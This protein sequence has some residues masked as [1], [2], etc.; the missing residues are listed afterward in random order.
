[1]MKSL[2]SLMLFVCSP[3]AYAGQPNVVFI[4][5]D[6]LGYGGL[7]CYGTRWLETPNIDGLCRE[8]MKFTEGLA[9]YPTCL[10]SRMAILT[11]QYGPRTGGYRVVDR[12]RGEEHLI[13]YLVPKN[14][15]LAHDK[16]TVAEC[17]QQAGY[18]TAMF[19]K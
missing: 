14:L 16:I 18:A 6:D 3:L 1:M 9:A 11:G 5:A 13:K 15:H 8:G 7:H 4:L 17:F 10:P 12:H 19:G 2:I